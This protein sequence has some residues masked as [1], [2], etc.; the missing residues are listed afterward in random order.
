MIVENALNAKPVHYIK[1]I[2]IYILILK[3]PMLQ[4]YLNASIVNAL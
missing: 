1:E 4:I 2:S 3:N